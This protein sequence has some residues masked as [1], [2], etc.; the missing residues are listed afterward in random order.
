MPVAQRGRRPGE[1]PGRAGMDPENRICSSSAT[2]EPRAGGDGPWLRTLQDGGDPKTPRGR[3]WAGLLPDSPRDAAENPALAGMDRF[4]TRQ[5]SSTSEEPRP[6]GWTAG[7][8]A[9]MDHEWHSSRRP[10]RRTPRERG[11]TGEH[12]GAYARHKS[13]RRGGATLSSPRT[14]RRG[15]RGRGHVQRSQGR[16]EA[17]AGRPGGE[18]R[19]RLPTLLAEAPPPGRNPAAVSLR[20]LGTAI[21]RLNVLSEPRNVTRLPTGEACDDIARFPWTNLG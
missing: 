15:R 19:P 3:G 5:P 20:S 12:P 8:I 11:W 21:R 4:R 6:R 2:G 14:R 17:A 13:Q 18:P 9:R 7:P 10:V 1:R 16:G